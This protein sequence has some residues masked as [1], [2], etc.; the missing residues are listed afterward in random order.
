MMLID[1]IQGQGKILRLDCS[2]QIWIWGYP[3][4]LHQI[5]VNLV[6][7][8]L[9]HAY[10]PDQPGEM[11][12]RLEQKQ[13]EIILLYQ[14]DG[15][16]MDPDTLNQA[17]HPFF[18]TRR[19]QG[20][21]GLGLAVVFNLVTQLYRG[22]ISCASTPQSGVLFR[23]ALPTGPVPADSKNPSPEGM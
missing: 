11:R 5:V 4:A 21:S 18:T 7:N 22:A 6:D 8:S 13:D 20:Y 12:I 15:K 17:F 1:K 10:D 19:S 9:V 2:G 16:G 23:I 14:D 3:R